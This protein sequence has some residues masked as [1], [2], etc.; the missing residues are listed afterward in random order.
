MA[1]RNARRKGRKLVLALATTT[2]LVASLLLGGLTANAILSG[3]PSK[4]EANDGDMIAGAANHDWNNVSFAHI[5]D[6]AAS[7]TDDSFTSGQKQDTTCPSIEGHKNPPKDDFTDVASFSDVAS[8]GDTFLYGATIRY[9][10]NGDAS[11]NV[12][13]KQ[14]TS[15]F[16]AGSTTLL[17]RTPGDKLLAIDYLNGGTSLDTHVLTWVGTGACFVS[18]DTAPCWG[19]TALSLGA[20]GAEGEAS[21]S[22]ITAENNPISS[23]DLASGQFAEFG[24]NLRV[25]GIIPAGQCSAFPQTVWESRSSGS[26]FVSTTKDVTIENKTI[27]NCGEVVII[28]HTNPRGLNHGF[29]FTSTLTGAQLSCTRSTATAFTLNDTGNTTAD[30]AGNTQDCTKVPVG[31]YT[32]TEGADPTGFAFASLSCTATGGAAGSQD[33]TVTKQAD[34]TMTA[35]G[36]VTCTY[37]NDQ[38][39]GAIKITKTSSKGTHPGLAGATFTITSGGT[40][41]SGSPFTTNANG[42]ICADHLAF[43]TY[44]VQETGAPTGYAIDD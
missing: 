19:A 28:K 35:G 20:A 24:V 16:C 21:Q 8:N 36:K 40:A 17:A 38:Q 18:T 39:T 5:A 37:V 15:G 1:A 42:V 23:Q 10:A 4:F 41:I 11:E 22:A 31:S 2:G 29:G 25:A 33:G 34:I 43:G 27:T 6:S 9:A 30:S 7:T 3:S 12:Q 13:L 26:S 44:S 32:V 14:G